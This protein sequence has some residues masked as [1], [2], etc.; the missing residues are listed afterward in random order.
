VSS[1]IS[2]GTLKDSQEA[3]TLMQSLNI[4]G[5][6]VNMIL[7]FP[8]GKIADKFKYK[9]S[10]SIASLVQLLLLVMFFRIESPNSLSTYIV[11][12]GMQSMFCVQNALTDGLFAKNIPTKIR[13]TMMSVY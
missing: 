9:N 6:F 1:F 3:Q 13:G 8:A 4:V 12:S 10:M 2:N 11:I 5:T 7:I